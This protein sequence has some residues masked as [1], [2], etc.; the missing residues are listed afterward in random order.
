MKEVTYT[1]GELKRIITESSQ[2]FKPKLGV[3]VER[4]DKRNNEK[5][6]KESEK[7]AKDYDGGLSDATKNK[8]VSQK[9]D[10]NGTTLDYDYV[11][12][13]SKEYKDRVKTQ[14]KGY[15]SELEEKNGIEKAADFDDGEEIYNF[16]KNSHEEVADAKKMIKKSGLAARTM[17]SNMFDDK[18]VYESK[19]VKRIYFKHTKF[20]NESHMLSL[21]PEEYKVGG[22][23]LIMKDANENEY[24][25]EWS[26]I[27]GKPE[28]EIL[29]SYNKKEINEN[30]QRI[31]DLFNYKSSNMF[32]QSTAKQ[33]ANEE[34]KFNDILNKAR[35]L[36]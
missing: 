30:L 27:N 26:I 3:N 21:I 12:E 28:A 33:R 19:T 9:V 34:K 17:P 18:N 25:V 24:L 15:T 7:R 8:K 2:E 6:Y 11:N 5:S 31:K 1:I 4:D 14:A 29:K 22:Q 13:P 20:D 35:S 23:K 16:F 32:K 36:K 10:A